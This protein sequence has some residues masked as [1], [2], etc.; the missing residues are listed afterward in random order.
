MLKADEWMQKNFTGEGGF[1]PLKERAMFF[2]SS[3]GYHTNPFIFDKES[4][5]SSYKIVNDIPK[6]DFEKYK[7]D[8]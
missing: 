3:T 8:S 5:I 6:E 7:V 1:G 4:S 2:S